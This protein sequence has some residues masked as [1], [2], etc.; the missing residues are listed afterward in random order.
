MDG[1]QQTPASDGANLY[2]PDEVI[3]PNAMPATA[4][5]QPVTPQLATQVLPTTDTTQPVA[6]SSEPAV[7]ISPTVPA[8]TDTPQP[9]LSDQVAQNI[10]DSGPITWT[11]SEYIAHQKSSNWYLGLGVAAIVIAAVVWL[12]T[13]DLFPSITVLVGVI[14]LGVYAGRQPNQQSY[15]LDD[16]GLAIGSR[17]YAYQD[18]RS[19]TVVPEG[20]FLSV[21]LTPLKRFAV[22]VTLYVDPDNE[23]RI[24]ARL[25]DHLP[26][27]EAKLNVAD[28]LMR[29]IRF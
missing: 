13:R 4:D 19:F 1:D 20:A 15:A 24:L 2:H 6:P 17:R 21:E 22:G 27:E 23:D 18:F 8:Q 3:R 28:S 11:A 10:T 16:H 25:S 12:L 14:I 26:I 7:P 9:Q 29:R 5:T